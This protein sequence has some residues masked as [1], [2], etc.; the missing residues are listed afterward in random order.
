VR[1]TKGTY[2]SQKSVAEIFKLLAGSPLLLLFSVL[3]TTTKR[4]E[5]DTKRTQTK[6]LFHY[7]KGTD[8]KASAFSQQENKRPFFSFSRLLREASPSFQR[9]L[10]TT[11]IH[12]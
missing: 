6:L 12:V 7:T 11:S 2:L 9:K 3:H 8:R 5:A 1:I 10:S 4:T